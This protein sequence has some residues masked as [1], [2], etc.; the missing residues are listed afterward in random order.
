MSLKKTKL[1]TPLHGEWN[2]LLSGKLSRRLANRA[3]FLKT[4]NQILTDKAFS[5]I[6]NEINEISIVLCDDKYI[7]GL[8]LEHRGKDKPTD[9]LSFPGYNFKGYKIKDPVASPLLGDL[10][11]SIDTTFE[12]AKRYRVTP[13][14]E[15]LRLVIHGLLHLSGYDHEKV[16]PSKAQQMRR[17]ERR[18]M[19]KFQR[20]LSLLK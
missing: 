3:I 11:I 8:N 7:H 19:A 13:S 10:V 17:A 9:V 15:L 2:F 5:N 6:P 18:I 14:R 12:Q 16:L 1:T 4:I 20:N